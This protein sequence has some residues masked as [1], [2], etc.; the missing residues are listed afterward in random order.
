M[1]AS[2]EEEAAL[3]ALSG[4]GAGCGAQA[5]NAK[6]DAINVAKVR[7]FMVVSSKGTN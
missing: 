1:T 2:P 5:T 3:V 6:V 4:A 7:I